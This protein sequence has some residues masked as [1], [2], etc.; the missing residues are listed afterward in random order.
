MYVLQEYCTYVPLLFFP[1]QHTY[2]PIKMSPNPKESAINTHISILPSS[3][4]L[5]NKWQL[6]LQLLYVRTFKKVSYE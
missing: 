1:Q 2:I 3:M 4:K 5:N 6:Y